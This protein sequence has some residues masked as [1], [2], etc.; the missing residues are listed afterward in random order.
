MTNLFILL[1]TYLLYYVCIVLFIFFVFYVYIWTF[2]LKLTLY[3][4][5]NTTQLYLSI[6]MYTYLRTISMVH[7]KCHYQLQ[8]K[9]G[10]TLSQDKGYNLLCS[11]HPNTMQR[12]TN[13]LVKG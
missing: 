7:H 9:Y 1:P 11:L 3:I 10:V 2:C 13:K 12:M 4:H 6:M 8:S 5:I